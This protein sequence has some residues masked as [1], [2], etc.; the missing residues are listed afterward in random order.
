[1]TNKREH[2]KLIGDRS[3]AMVLARLLE[4]YEVVLLPFGE[5]QRYDLVIEDGEKFIRV[6]CKTG[7]LRKGVVQFPTR[8]VTY[9]HPNQPIQAIR[10]HNYRGQADVFGVYCPETDGVYLVPVDEVGTRQGS[11]RV[12]PTRNSQ[13]K[14]IRWAV[15]YGVTRNPDNEPSLERPKSSTTLFEPPARYSMRAVPG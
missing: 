15:A 12:E 11:L 3:T 7:R 2:P 10:T 8:S 4:V 13:A 9:H 5:N 1:M 6:Q 14:L